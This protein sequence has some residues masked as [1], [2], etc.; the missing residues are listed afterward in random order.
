MEGM[1]DGL[2]RGNV[3]KTEEGLETYALEDRQGGGREG[4]KE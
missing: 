3:E 4:L 2:M 1:M